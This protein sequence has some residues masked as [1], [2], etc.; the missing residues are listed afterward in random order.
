M[1]VLAQGGE[2]QLRIAVEDSGPGVPAH[3]RSRLFDEFSR[4]EEAAGANGSG[5]GLA[6]AR[7]Y[8]AA[9]QGDLLYD[10]EFSSGA[11]FEFVLPQE[12]AL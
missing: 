2:R 3:I 9:H 11:R 5:L 4:G 7:S 1:R 6:I 10:E 8:A 12:T